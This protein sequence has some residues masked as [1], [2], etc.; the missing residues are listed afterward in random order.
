[1][2]LSYRQHEGN[3]DEKRLLP[4]ESILGHILVCETRLM[5]HQVAHLHQVNAR[6]FGHACGHLPE[7]DIYEGM[8]DS[9]ISSDV[10]L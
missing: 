6:L 5:G 9:Q 2:S 8:A 10:I 7:M 4:T 1:M 3:W